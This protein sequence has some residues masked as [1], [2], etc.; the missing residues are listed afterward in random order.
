MTDMDFS[1]DGIPM[2][3][4]L[5]ERAHNILEEKSR[6]NVSSRARPFLCFLLYNRS[7]LCTH[8]SSF[9]NYQQ[10]AQLISVVH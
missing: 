9:T 3:V 5:T 2:V 4:Y 10:R 8:D 1:G 7:I 6:V